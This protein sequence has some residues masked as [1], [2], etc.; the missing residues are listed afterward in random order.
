MD[1]CSRPHPPR[2]SKPDNSNR[3]REWKGRDRDKGSEKG[4]CKE[5]PSEVEGCRGKE[6]NTERERNK[7]RTKPGRELQRKRQRDI[8]QNDKEQR[9]RHTQRHRDRGRQGLKKRQ[10]R[11]AR[12]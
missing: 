5:R 6:R 12:N 4:I 2:G 8:N 7:C 10:K 9:H 1:Y 3:T 11:V